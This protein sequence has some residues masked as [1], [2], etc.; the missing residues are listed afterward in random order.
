MTLLE[1]TFLENRYRIDGLLAHGGMGSIY[2]GFDTNLSTPVAIK[3]N[4][5][6]S[7]HHIAQF[8]QE[9]LILARLR[10]PALPRV[11]HHFS[12]EGQQYLVMDFIDGENLW[13]LIERRGESLPEN[14][15]LDYLIQVCQAV[16]YLHR[17]KPPII[18]RDIKPQNIKITPTG[19]AMLVDFGIAKLAADDKTQTEIGAQGTTSGFSPPEQ[20]GKG[21]TGPAS[22][23]YALGATLYTALTGQKPP[24][25]LVLLAG[26]AKLMPPQALNSVL[27]P[28]LEGVIKQAMQPKVED[29]PSAV[30]DWQKTLEAIAGVTL[31]NT[32]TLASKSK[33]LLSK[34]RGGT[35][36][37]AETAHRQ[38]SSTKYWLVDPTGMGYP[39][40]SEPLS[41]GRHSSA[42]VTLDD[43][44]IS[45]IHTLLRVE[46]K[47]CLVKDENSANGTFLNGHRLSSEWYP[48]NQGDVLIIGPARFY[49]TSTQPAKLAPPKVKSAPASVAPL[50]TIVEATP[51]KVALNDAQETLKAV[52]TPPKARHNSW[53]IGGLLLIILLL[54]GLAA[55]LWFNQST[56]ARSNETALQLSPSPPVEVIITPSADLT[57]GVDLTTPVDLRP[58]QQ[59]DPG[60][61]QTV[62]TETA[63]KAA[64]TGQAEATTIPTLSTNTPPLKKTPVTKISKT[65]TIITP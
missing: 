29:R 62:T 35:V 27:N 15:A 49:L 44:N 17:Q 37:Q 55:Y 46:G 45:R 56:S 43:L 58:T 6:R 20:Y 51:K 4:F 28:E 36:A 13:G 31:G 14:E 39:L 26:K 38:S 33:A 3:E 57:T 60:S 59:L 65:A 10:H 5:L 8:K 47:R 63:T 11:M 12:F 21:G 18:H 30:I 40:G 19:R 64:E 42:G 24:H 22:D 48:L 34:S 41:I 7:S 1:D 32:A 50:E 25:S 2:R 9:A 52:A 61:Q 16:N 53:L 54:A 23:I